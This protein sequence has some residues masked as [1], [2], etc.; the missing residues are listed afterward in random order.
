ML[1]SLLS[2]ARNASN[3]EWAKQAFDEI[4]E[5]DPLDA[6]AHALM[7]TTYARNEMWHENEQIEKLM[8]EKKISRLPAESTIFV[9]GKKECFRVHDTS[10]PRIHEI[11]QQLKQHVEL[12]KDYGYVPD[13]SCV[14]NSHNL[15][16]SEIEESLCGHAEKLS[17]MFGMMSLPKNQ[18]IVVTKNINMC[19]DCHNMVRL[20]T[21]VK[22]REI[23][24]QDASRLHE[25]KNGVCS[26]D[27][28]GS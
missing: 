21:S 15:S 9:D 24:V 6:A 14:S 18:R 19:R 22:D 2:E 10:H 16:D 5:L 11:R 20:T 1:R 13:R 26:C 23:H 4:M 17:I 3:I 28:F 8:K 25:M 12:L 27:G 7:A